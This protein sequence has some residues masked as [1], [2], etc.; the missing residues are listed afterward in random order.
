[1]PT[2]PGTH[3]RPPAFS[4]AHF[5]FSARWR[6]FFVE[7]FLEHCDEMNDDMLFFVRQLA[8]EDLG[9]DPVFVRRKMKDCTMPILD[10]PVLWKETFFLNLIVQV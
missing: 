2:I 5:N 9:Q 3:L 4:A 8:I 1:M 7:Y 10:D 6:K